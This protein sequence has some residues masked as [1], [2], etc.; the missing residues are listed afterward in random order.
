MG[1]PCE[2]KT[3]VAGGNENGTKQ[4]AAQKSHLVRALQAMGAQVVGEKEEAHDE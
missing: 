1:E 4:S 2:I 3:A